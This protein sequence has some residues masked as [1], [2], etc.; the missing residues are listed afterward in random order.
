MKNLIYLLVAV[1][2]LTACSTASSD[3][4][5]FNVEMREYNF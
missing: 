1:L 3:V 4:V 2:T 5:E